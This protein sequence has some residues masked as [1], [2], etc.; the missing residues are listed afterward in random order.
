MT[1]DGGSDQRVIKGEGLTCYVNTVR[2]TE[3]G[4]SKPP[5]DEAGDVQVGCK[6]RMCLELSAALGF[7]AGCCSASNRRLRLHKR[8]VSTFDVLRGADVTAKNITNMPR[9][10]TG[11]ACGSSETACC[12]LPRA[13]APPESTNDSVMTSRGL[14]SGLHCDA[15]LTRVML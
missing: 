12:I 7:Y 10:G 9:S 4:V 5:C 3:Q 2:D 6:Q 8:Q 14:A 11:G 1:E 15:V 13:W